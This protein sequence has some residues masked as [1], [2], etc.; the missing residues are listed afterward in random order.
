MSG[1]TILAVGDE[2]QAEL[3]TQQA[4]QTQE[5]T[6]T[7]ETTEG[8]KSTETTE[9]T[10]TAETTEGTETTEATETA[11]TTEEHK[12]YWGDLP[13]EIEV[14]QEIASALAE[15]KID[16]TKLVDELFAKDG[17]FE[18][19]EQSRKALDKAFGK[20]I[21][22]GYLGLYKQ[23]NEMFM[24]KHKQSMEDLGKTLEANAADFE[25]LIGG[26]EGWQELNEWA[27]ANLSEG[28]IANLNAVMQLPVEHYQAQRT[29]IEALQVKRLKATA[30]AAGDTEVTLLTDSGSPSKAS[31]GALPASL[32][33]EEFQ[34]LFNSERYGKDPKWAAQVDGIRR[35]SQQAEK[36]QRR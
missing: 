31:T 6:E 22:D 34:A 15:H 9:V 10:E 2:A 3:E 12:H 26:D 7:T 11:E 20:T 1:N 32:T 21:V 8:T 5:S 19:S 27:E 29:V 24:D 36:P 35:R 17:K 23:Q 18:L 30:E 14:P 16:A 4:Q 33:R 13:V 28:E 25:E